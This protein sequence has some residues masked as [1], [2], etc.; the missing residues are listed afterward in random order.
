M[1]GTSHTVT[2]ILGG[3][4]SGKS[5]RAQALA[6]ATGPNCCYIATAQAFD[7]EM[8][9]RIAA[10]QDARGE[11]WS[12]LEAPLELA[13]AISSAATASCDVILIDCLTLW[14][15]NLMHHERNIAEETAR[16]TAALKACPVPVIVVSNEVGL[17]IV[18]EN[19][20]AR[21]FRDAQGRLNQ[22]VAAAADRVELVAAGLPLRLKD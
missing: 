6:E 11:G 12:T 9:D 8:K 7:D 15:S 16:L 4:R 17:S 13:E 10:H 14:L 19:Q 18:P 5:S 1:A 22:D 2:F 21:A 3:A 20:L